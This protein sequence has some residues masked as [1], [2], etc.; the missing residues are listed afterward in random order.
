MR[1][2]YNYNANHIN[3]SLYNQIASL[4]HRVIAYI[5]SFF[6]NPQ[7]ELPIVAEESKPSFFHRVK[8]K[9]RENPKTSL[10]IGVGIS[11]IVATSLYYFTSAPPSNIT[12][13]TSFTTQPDRLALS[14]KVAT[15][16][17]AYCDANGYE[18]LVYRENLAKPALPY[19]SK[20]AGMNKLLNDS[21]FA[22]RD[23]FVW[24]DDDMV[25]MNHRIRIEE[26]V[27]QFHE[28]SVIVTEDIQLPNINTGVIFVK[29]D[30]VSRAIFQMLWDMRNKISKS[31]HPY[32]SCPNQ[33]CLHEQEALQDLISRIWDVRSF[34]KIIPQ[35]GALDGLWDVG[36]NTF[37]RFSHYD[38][39]RDKMLFYDDPLRIRGKIGDFAT[40]CTGMATDGIKL[41]DNLPGNF[42][43]M[44]IDDLISKIRR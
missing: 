16:H 8:D 15:T 34:V 20:V 37:Q 18:Y 21:Q 12:V 25:M 4:V 28:Y 23:W 44:C 22:S 42:R 35:R 39:N 2:D 3:E 13:F 27:N 7:E 29:N 30:D 10:A 9:I 41:V 5:S 11:L 19:W 36:I 38:L 32:T 14:E 33:I 6:M 26:I 43:E 40:Q 31:G 17:Q 24:L 1:V